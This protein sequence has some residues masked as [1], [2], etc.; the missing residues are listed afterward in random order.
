L[1]AEERKPIMFVE[2]DGMDSDNEKL[3]RNAAQSVK[4]TTSSKGTSHLGYRPL[5]ES[6]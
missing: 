3:K 1:V 5:D 2:D 6:V 4:S